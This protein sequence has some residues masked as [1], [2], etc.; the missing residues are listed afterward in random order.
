M[1]IFRL[2]GLWD[3]AADRLAHAAHQLEQAGAEFLGRV[4][5]LSNADA[6]RNCASVGAQPS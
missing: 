3:A 4:A 5:R 1:P 2:M 6:D